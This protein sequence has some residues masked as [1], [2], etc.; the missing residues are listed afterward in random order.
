[1]LTTQQ[2][3]QKKISYIMNNNKIIQK[4]NNY[5]NDAIHFEQNKLKGMK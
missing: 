2:N 3:E 1:M 5:I 4:E